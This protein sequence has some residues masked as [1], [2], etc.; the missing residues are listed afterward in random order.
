[1]HDFSCHQASQQLYRESC[2]HMLLMHHLR[3]GFRITA[4]LRLPQL[5]AEYS[6]FG[7][8]RRSKPGNIDKETVLTVDAEIV[9][10]AVESW[11]TLYVATTEAEQDR[12]LKEMFD[13]DATFEDP[14]IKVRWSVTASSRAKAPAVTPHHSRVQAH[15]HCPVRIEARSDQCRLIHD[16]NDSHIRP[17]F[18]MGAAHRSISHLWCQG[19]THSSYSSCTDCSTEYAWHVQHPACLHTTARVIDMR[20]ATGGTYLL[21]TL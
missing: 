3:R 20:T 17:S 19:H 13:A 4:R 11:K 6:M 8:G 10:Q 18:V 21:T 1:M 16:P 5:H 15:Q 7:I 14:L 2:S 9:Q 12:A